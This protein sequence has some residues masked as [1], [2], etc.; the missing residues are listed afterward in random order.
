MKNKVKNNKMLIMGVAFI[1]IVLFVGIIF[2]ILGVGNNDRGSALK[3]APSVGK[4]DDNN[5]LTFVINGYS[6][7]V[8]YLNSEIGSRVIIKEYSTFKNYFS[9]YDNMKNVINRYNEDF[10]VGS[11]LAIQYVTVNSGSITIIDVEG[12]VIDNKVSITYEEKRPEVGTADM[13]GYFLIVEVPKTVEE[14]A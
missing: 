14:I 12:N 8:G 7:K 5:G 10:F 13:S 4:T 6:V 1:V 3:D 9:K 2:I 11:S